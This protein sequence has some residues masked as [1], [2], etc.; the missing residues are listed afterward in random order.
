M[1]HAFNPLPLPDPDDPYLDYLDQDGGEGIPGVTPEMYNKSFGGLKRLD[2]FLG[3]WWATGWASWRGYDQDPDSS[4]SPFLNALIENLEE[5]NISTDSGYAKTDPETST[6]IQ[7]WFPIPVTTYPSLRILNLRDGEIRF[8]GLCLFL[9][10]NKATLQ[11]FKAIDTAFGKEKQADAERGGFLPFLEWV[12]ENMSFQKF[13][14]EVVVS[15]EGDDPDDPDFDWSDEKNMVRVRVDG[16]WNSE[17]KRILIRRA[18]ATDWGLRQRDIEYWKG[19]S[20][21]KFIEALQRIDVNESIR[22]WD[23]EGC[24]TRR[25]EMEKTRLD[26]LKQH[27]EE[28]KLADAGRSLEMFIDFQ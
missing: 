11:E 20:W 9:E 12:K 24:R 7:N 1:I 14:C 13:D 22:C 10:A 23:C 4:K 5:L 16:D 19:S 18:I 25:E 6:L 26:R 17:G 8:P 21:D 27:A 28:A 15:R 2:I 3:R